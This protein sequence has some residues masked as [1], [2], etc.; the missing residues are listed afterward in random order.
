MQTNIETLTGSNAT[1]ILR[2]SHSTR[3]NVTLVGLYKNK[4]LL[5]SFT[6]H[7][8]SLKHAKANRQYLV[9]VKKENVVHMF[10]ASVKKVETGPF[11]L[12]H[13]SLNQD[14]IN[15]KRKTPRVGG[16]NSK[17]KLSL[18]K[19]NDFVD[20]TMADISTAGA[21]LVAKQRLGNIDDAFVI[22]VKSQYSDES[23][24]IRCKICHLRTEIDR[25]FGSRIVFHHG[26]EFVDI[27][28]DAKI[29]LTQF[30]KEIMH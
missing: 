8:D 14:V 11:P 29:F 7:E 3:L 26:V 10:N 9:Q 4:Y 5:A 19:G 16:D 21:R 13:L 12:V 6:G 18:Q 28:D 2:D 30:V 15:T 23:F 20:V 1:L 17:I 22:D 25:D 27:D 24:N